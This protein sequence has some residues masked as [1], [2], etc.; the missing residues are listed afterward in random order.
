MEHQIIAGIFQVVD[1]GNLLHIICEK[2]A[3]YLSLELGFPE[4]CGTGHKGIEAGEKL[5]EVSLSAGISGKENQQDVQ[6][7]IYPSQGLDAY[8][9]FKSRN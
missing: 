1:T 8:T 4:D 6:A 5:S 7:K 3:L 9:R 2:F